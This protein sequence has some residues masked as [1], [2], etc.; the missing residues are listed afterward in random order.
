[1]PVVISPAKTSALTRVTIHNET[2]APITAR[3]ETAMHAPAGA[4]CAPGGTSPVRLDIKHAVVVP[5]HGQATVTPRGHVPAGD[6]LVG[7]KVTGKTVNGVGVNYVLDS[8]QVVRW[9]G[10]SAQCA[11]SHRVTHTVMP[12]HAALA[13]RPGSSLPVAGIAIVAVLALVVLTVAA[14]GLRRARAGR[15]GGARAR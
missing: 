2:D 11:V 14:L 4:R 8:Q 7:W 12:H 9:G 3:P 1:M 15:T 13:S 6:Y 5:A 10:N